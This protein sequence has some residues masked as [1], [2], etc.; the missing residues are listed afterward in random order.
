MPE[1]VRDRGRNRS[2]KERTESQEGLRQRRIMRTV[3]YE[4]EYR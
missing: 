2:T 3:E 1:L 4:A